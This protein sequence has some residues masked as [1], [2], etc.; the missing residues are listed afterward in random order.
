MFLSA[1]NLNN[2]RIMN[3][4]NE[5]SNESREKNYQHNEKLS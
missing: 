1:L 2:V 3:S 4:N 5:Q